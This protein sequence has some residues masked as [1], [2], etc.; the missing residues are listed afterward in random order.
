MFEENLKHEVQ[1]RHD[2]KDLIETYDRLYKPT[3]S[4]EFNRE[5]EV[6]L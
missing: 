2:S 6:L 5:G 4:I 3:Y 1:R